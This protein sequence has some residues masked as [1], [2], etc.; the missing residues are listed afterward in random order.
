MCVMALID[1]RIF[2][3]AL[4]AC[5]RQKPGC[6]AGLDEE[7]SRRLRVLLFPTTDEVTKGQFQGLVPAKYERIR[8]CFLLK[9]EDRKARHSGA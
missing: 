7:A 2:T 6:S 9:A 5:G 8:A 4:W 3:W 1:A